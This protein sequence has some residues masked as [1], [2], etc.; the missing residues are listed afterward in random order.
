LKIKLSFEKK[1]FIVGLGIFIIILLPFVYQIY[2]RHH[3]PQGYY[4]TGF[5]IS[6]QNT[7]SAIFRSVFERGNGIFYSY[8]YAPPG[9]D[10]PAIMFQIPF[11]LLAWF[12]KL[13]TSTRAAWEIL[14][15]VF[16][17]GFLFLLYKFF[18]RVFQNFYPKEMAER[19]GQIISRGLFLTLLFGA[20]LAWFIAAFRFGVGRFAGTLPFESSYLDTFIDVESDYSGWIFN[21]FR[22]VFNPLE[23]IYHLCFFLAVLG[24][25]RGNSRLAFAGQLLA[26]GSGVFV[27]LEISA[28]ML[29]FFI[30]EY[31]YSKDKKHLKQ[32]VLSF[33]ILGV[34]I[35][36]YKIFM[37]FFPVSRSLVEQ[38]LINLHGAIPLRCYFPAY[39]FLLFSTPL[40]FLNRDFR[41]VFF[42]KREGRLLFIWLFVV[43]CLIQND[44]ILTLQRSVQP[45]HFARGYLFTALFL[46]SALGAFPFFYRISQRRFLKLILI[47]SALFILML[48]DNLLYLRRLFTFEPHPHFLLLPT[49]SME[50]FNYLNGLNTRENIFCSDIRLGDQIPAFTPHSSVWAMEYATPF[51]EDKKQMI[52][53]FYNNIGADDFI[54]KYKISMLIILNTKAAPLAEKIKR[55]EWKEVFGNDIWKVYQIPR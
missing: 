12:W 23:G 55:P 44:K 45:A 39:G 1:D 43:I 37:R 36:Y 30:I 53:G 15:I 29:L 40:V 9:S 21:I 47:M 35:F 6:D 51:A 27:G 19:N 14:R 5:L 22:N 11:T 18:V 33:S 42:Q 24:A 26:C 50:V 38:H 31:L 13:T 52:A 7:Y 32:F 48:P 8:P 20:G 54:K 16:G 46:I 25:I 34:F 4:Y 41:R 2:W 17:I 28:I 3:T 49:Q 10:N